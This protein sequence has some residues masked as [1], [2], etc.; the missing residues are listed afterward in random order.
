MTALSKNNGIKPAI[1]IV[2]DFNRISKPIIKNW[3]N[4]PKRNPIVT[5]LGEPNPK[6]AATSIPGT[7]PGKMVF[8]IPWNDCVNSSTKVLTPNC[9]I[10]K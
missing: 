5:A 10:A 9:K 2:G 7:A 3:P 8:E 1:T 6:V 4:A